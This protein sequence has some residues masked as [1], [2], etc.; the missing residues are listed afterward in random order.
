[1]ALSIQKIVSSR[2][3]KCVL[4]GA[5][6]AFFVASAIGAVE[7]DILF[8][9][10]PSYSTS[11]GGEANAQVSFANVAAAVNFL[12]D[13]SGTGARWHIA[14]YYQS[15]NDPVNW[16]T[17]GGMVGWL[18]GNNANVSDVVSCGS[19]VGADLVLYVVQNSDSGSIAGV[20]QQPGMYSSIN[21][22]NIWSGVVAH[23]IGGHAYG[24]NHQDGHIGPS[25]PP[26]TIMMHNYCVGGGATPPYFFSNPNI[27]WN[28][29]QLLGNGQTCLGG[30]QVN[31]GDNA[32]CL[33]ANSQG[34]TDRRERPVVGPLLTNIILHWCFTNALGAAP[35]GTTNYDLVSGAPAA[36]RGNGA[37][38]TGSALRLPGGT[39]GNVAMSSMAAYID[40]PNSILSSQTNITIEIWATPL[41]AQNW[42]RIMDFGRCTEAG[43]GLGAPGEF[44][45]IPSD[46]APG[47]TSQSD[48]L[49][50]TACI[51]TDITQQR[52]ESPH[53][54]LVV[55]DNSGLATTPGVQHC[56]AITFTDGAGSF[57]SSGGRWQWY[58]DGDP[59]GFLD[60][61]NHLSAIQ[62]V[63][64]WLGRSEW[65]ADS[66][67]NN[68]YSE[69]RISNVA[70][71]RGQV[72]ANYSLG[73]NFNISNTT[74]LTA[75]D[76]WAG[77]TRSFNTAGN[78]S[79]GLAP[80]AGKNYDMFDFNL[81]TPN[82][83]TPY[84]FAGSSLRGSGGIFFCGS[85][86]TT[87]ISVPSF[88]V[89]KEEICNGTTASGSTFTLA[90][91]LNVNGNCVVRGSTGPINLAAN[92]NGTGSITLYG[93]TAT[94]TGNNANYTG[95]IRIGNGIIGSLRLSSE[96]QLGANP[97]AF[98]SDQL[99]LNRGW[100]YT[101]TSFAISNSNRGILIGVN[102]GIFDVGA[103]STLTLG[104]K[105]SSGMTLTSASQLSTQ[106]EQSGVVAGAL[107][108]QDSGT[109]V[110]NSPNSGFTGVLD[111]DSS[112]STAN[113][114]AVRIAN[115]S[116]LANAYSPI[117]IRNSSSG[118]ST[119]QLDGT[120]NSVLLPQ[121][122]SLNGRNIAV[123]AIE[124]IAG[125]NTIAGGIS[126]Y[127]S[128]SYLVQVDSGILNIG[129][130]IT[131][132][133]SGSDTITFQ[134]NG[135]ANLNG[136]VTGPMS[137]NKSGN[138]TLAFGASSTYTGATTVTQG[139][140]ALQP[141]T[142]PVLHLTFNNTAGSGNG[143]VIT[144]T[145]TGGSAMN[146]TLVTSGGASITSSGRFGNALSLNGTG[147]NASNNIVLIPNK[148][149]NTDAS[150]SWTVGYW[151]KTTT[152]GAVVMYQGDGGWSSAGQTTFYLNS[153]NTTAGTRAGAVRW[154]GGWLTG[155]TALNNNVWHFIT[156]VD[157]AGTEQIYVDGN[158]DTLAS[159]M[160]NPL[161]SD[162]NQI[163]IGGSPDGGDGATKM[164][165]T[166]DEVYM[167]NRALSQSEV[168]SLFAN[169]AITNT[170][171]NT[172]PTTTPVT[173]GSSGIL[174]LAGVSQTIASLAGSGLVT[175]T[176]GP[177]TLTISKSSGTTTFGG[178][179]GD[180]SA[181]NALSLVQSGGSTTVLSGSNTYRGTTSVNGGIL[182]VNGAI[183]SGAVTVN[184]AGTLG[185]AGTIGGSVTVQ[186]GGT[187]SPG[188][189]LNS[190]IVNNDVALQPG[191]TTFL[192]I[193]KT[194]QT[195][196][197]LI[198]AGALTYGGT[199]VVTNL[200][201]T[202]AAGDAFQLFQA[203]SIS[204][205][206]DSYT[207]PSLDN[208]LVWNTS[209]LGSGTISVVQITPTNIVWN[210][211]GTNLN[212][213]WPAGY[214]GWRLQVQTN[215]L[216]GTN[217]V[218][219]PG[220]S[221]TNFEAL[222]VDP[223]VQSMFYRLIYP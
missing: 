208:G 172:L 13:Q 199:L 4:A 140:L 142:L 141:S 185:G 76:E 61:S 219:V 91:N 3:L 108:K 78:W 82:T 170:P 14:G 87:T 186:P 48:G 200:S 99:I 209:K 202:P 217:W 16:T 35:A 62:D 2:R 221:V 81:I 190:L 19:T 65:S 73:P 211:T 216:N 1:M 158:L 55:T 23:E 207:L 32:Y 46:P 27:W 124:N 153:S 22:G 44:T 127:G 204:G 222:P 155:T 123:A 20:S 149:L 154:A 80:G 60:V 105:L 156:L 104:S 94:I 160:A 88:I 171:V 100:L 84:T 11:L 114:G 177:A 92:L 138:G 122:V 110:L 29:T 28:N 166:I 145:G 68:D 72:A 41:S 25:G 163:W 180:L 102:D 161:A 126:T 31:G 184:N 96:A 95:K 101:T 133:D 71:S 38:Y 198:V 148:V 159:T 165:G 189:A 63:N 26:K 36:V 176:G 117:F 220:S 15:I 134:G 169:N 49:T 193:S 195:N 168:Q 205:T 196:D 214:I 192:E 93:N 136:T 187:L 188:G 206:F 113:D 64:D 77:S 201:G 128:G 86:G 10:A 89:E 70:M 111:V 18:S 150:G 56:Y 54:G 143:A 215:T 51:G 6:F 144:N 50:L 194:P 178:S 116:V 37:T 174:D 146:G 106:A 167:F 121:G 112:S 210:V 52:F 75:N 118:R 147:S 47:T 173:I 218:D 67:A 152:T 57:G 33:S 203:G 151:I 137:V 5:T 74:M 90:G 191:S 103:G 40:L 30:S 179:I 58:R 109:L 135:S 39:T 12:Y 164:N 212:F 59:V 21:P 24:G 120:L 79:D 129:G 17:T 213:S 162:A 8:S 53:N 34:V 7:Q 9:Y 175:N 132:S 119:L 183:G 42:A 125:T 45:G 223:T 182:L 197:Q 85:S 181:G 43:D 115:S 83:T 66:L 130:V 69:V 157:S 139:T 97:P 131:S 107:I 98:T